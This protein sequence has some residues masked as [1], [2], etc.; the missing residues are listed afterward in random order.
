MQAETPDATNTCSTSHESTVLTSMSTIETAQIPMPEP[1]RHVRDPRKVH[2]PQ[3]QQNTEVVHMPT[4]NCTMDNNNGMSP[5]KRF[6]R[7]PMKP[8]P[9]P[10]QSINPE[11][12][13][14]N[15]DS[16]DEIIAEWQIIERL[17]QRKRK[18]KAQ[19]YADP[20]I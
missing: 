12:N 13:I 8:R 14:T 16:M 9:Q 2:P 11:M 3:R 5:P 7:K 6:I 15:F 18:R 17:L 1:T 4:Q 19:Q 20:S 10:P